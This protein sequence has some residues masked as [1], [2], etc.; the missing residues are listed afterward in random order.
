MHILQIAPPWAPVPPQG[1]GGTER[2]VAALCDELVKLGHEVTLVCAGKADTLARVIYTSQENPRIDMTADL[3]ESAHVLR[4]LDV[5][6]EGRFDV[7]HNHSSAIAACVLAA[8]PPPAPVLHTVHNALNVNTRRFLAILPHTISIN[9]I[10]ADHLSSFPP[11]HRTVGFVHN[12]VTLPTELSTKSER[13]YL[14]FVGRSAKGKAPDIAIGVASA[15]GLPLKMA[16][17]IDEEQE[18]SYWRTRVEP[19]LQEAKVDVEVHPATTL[20]ERTRLL[21]AARATLFPIRWREPFGLVPVE[22]MAAGTPV[23]AYDIGAVRELIVP[24]RTGYLAPAGDFSALCA[25][26]ESAMALDPK[27]CIARA[28]RSF[29]AARMALQYVRLYDGLAGGRDPADASRYG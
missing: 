22:S 13:P 15:L 26:A 8:C 21:S 24:G 20:S 29:S 18:R 3:S 11:G 16:V 19:V 9:A 5:A 2:V 7:V 25:A 28:Q 4:A 17:K 10:S 23:A 6:R 14:A 1:Y 12:G 27:D